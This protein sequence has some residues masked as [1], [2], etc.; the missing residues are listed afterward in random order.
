MKSV[1]RSFHLVRT[2]GAILSTFLR[3]EATS[4]AIGLLVVC[5]QTT[6][7]AKAIAALV[8]QPAAANT[9]FLKRLCTSIDTR[10]DLS[11]FKAICIHFEC[12]QR[13]GEGQARQRAAAEWL[14]FVDNYRPFLASAHLEWLNG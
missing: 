7:G 10:T 13:T 12:P 3:I 5:A 11:R 6:R 2:A 8:T 14:P 9:P 4:K 1:R